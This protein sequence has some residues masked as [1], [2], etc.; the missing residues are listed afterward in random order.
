MLSKKTVSLEVP[1]TGTDYGDIERSVSVPKTVTIKGTEDDIKDISKI[2]C[3]TLRCFGSLH[4]RYAA[5]GTY[6]S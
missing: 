1:V 4:Q 2:T 3:R 5:P 6:T